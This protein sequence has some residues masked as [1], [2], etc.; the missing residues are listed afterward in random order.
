MVGAKITE[1]V[2]NIDL[3][4]RLE[5]IIGGGV[6]DRVRRAGRLGF[7]HLRRTALMQAWNEKLNQ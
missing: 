2:L 4:E 6:D 3:V 7:E 1:Q 5:Q